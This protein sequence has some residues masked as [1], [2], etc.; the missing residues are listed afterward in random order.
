MDLIGLL[1]RLPG[2]QRQPKEVFL[3]LQWLSRAPDSHKAQIKPKCVFCLRQATQASLSMHDMAT[4]F[5]FSKLS[6]KK[7]L[8]V[9]TSF[10]FDG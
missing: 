10:I 7:I 9:G 6:F 2:P 1:T 4:V 8:K 3:S 5:D